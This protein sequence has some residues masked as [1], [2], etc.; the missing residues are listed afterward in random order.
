MVLCLSLACWCLAFGGYAEMPGILD[1]LKLVK[2]RR[3][4]A[5]ADLQSLQ[6]HHPPL[7]EV[8][9]ASTMAAPAA[10]LVGLLPS[11]LHNLM[12]YHDYLPTVL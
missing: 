7:R 4:E 11:L 8:Q 5:L 1:L 12:R 10:A 3:A 9:P 6:A 2:C